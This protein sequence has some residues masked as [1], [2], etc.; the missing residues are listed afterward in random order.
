MDKRR[1]I[2]VG[3]AVVFFLMVLL[4]CSTSG[5]LKPGPGETPIDETGKKPGWAEVVPAPDGM[6]Q[7]FVGLSAPF[8]T[9]K[10]AREDARKD[11]LNQVVQ[12]GGGIFKNKSEKIRMSNN[13]SSEVTNPTLVARVY[14]KHLS[15]KMIERVK[16]LEYYIEK[17]EKNGNIAYKA[18]VLMRMPNDLFAKTL[19]DTFAEQRDK[20][21]KLGQKQVEETQKLFKELK[22]DKFFN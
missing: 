5:P 8:A 6:F 21:K 11:A 12:Y 15:I 9:E 17:S 16:D 3:V 22:K 10:G 7:Y 18:Y 19:E 14:E 20:A 13:L 4:G 2:C 1:I